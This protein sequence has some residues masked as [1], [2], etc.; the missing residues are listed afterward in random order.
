MDTERRFLYAPPLLDIEVTLEITAARGLF[1]ALPSALIAYPSEQL[2]CIV[3]SIA[4][5]YSIL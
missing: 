3:T 5:A 2:S 1:L 4:I